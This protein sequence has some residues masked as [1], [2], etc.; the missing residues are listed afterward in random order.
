[1]DKRAVLYLRVSDPSQIEN[2]SLE[3]QEKVCKSFAKTHGYAVVQIYRDEGKSAKHVY[4][5]PALRELL[6]FCTKKNNIAAVI[7]YKFDRFSRD[8]SEGLAA[9]AILA[10]TNTQ[11]I[12][13]T[14]V[15]EI[16]PMNTALRTILIALGQL[17]NEV[18]AERVKDNMLNAFR[19]GAWPFKCPI[20][21]K[22]PYKTKEENKGKTIIQDPAIAPIVRNMFI[23]AAKGIYS[24]SQLARMMNLEGFE[25][26]YGKAMDHKTVDKMIQNSFYFGKMYARKWNEY[27]AGNHEPLIDQATWETAY[28]AVTHK[29][30][31]FKFQDVSLY[32]LKGYLV[33]S[34]CGSPMTTCPAHGRNR[35]FHYYECRNHT[36]RKT[37]VDA[38]KAHTQLSGL[39]QQIKP[40]ERVLKLF[41]HMVFSEWDRVIEGAR[42]R[43]RALDKRIEGLRDE[44]DTVVKAQ[45]DGLY[46]LDE[47]K[48]KVESIRKEIAVLEIER[49]ESRYAEYDTEAVRE[50]TNQFLLNLDALWERVDLPKKQALLERV[51][52]GKLICNTNR[53]IRTSKLS[54]SFELIKALKD[55]NV[56]NVT[57][58]GFE[59][60]LAG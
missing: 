54:Q 13:A 38:E 9:I 35:I 45:G 2:N 6:A 50:F 40:S 27:A 18:K 43:N 3:T 46:T 49:S 30:S 36:C 24:K 57:S 42:A 15:S 17:D 12:S 41:N 58:L 26:A 47:A 59:P 48:E 34:E 19:R 28:K 16:N 33:C 5:R 39:L 37:R 4:T 29:R 22:R 53:E 51:F 11:V 23:N 7:V 56:K 55:G 52:D 44:Q 14:E 32:P 25:K 10:K 1:M 31:Q 21:Y 8:A 60:K 20:G